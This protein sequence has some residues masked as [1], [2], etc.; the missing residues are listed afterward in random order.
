M[1]IV[2]GIGLL[3]S[4]PY[5]RLLSLG[6]GVYAIITGVV[7]G[8]IGGCVGIIYPILLNSFMTRPP[9]VAACQRSSP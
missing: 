9:M 8:V 1:L 2:A 3:Q 7:G 6:Y 4:Q 5:G